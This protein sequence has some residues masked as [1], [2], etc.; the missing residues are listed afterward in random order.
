MNIL[1]YTTYQEIN[2]DWV[3]QKII[4][5][6]QKVN[7]GGGGGTTDHTQLINRDAANQH[8]MSAITGLS[9]ALAG[10]QPAG[11]YVTNTQLNGAVDDAL[12][13][14]KAS[15][16]FDGAQGPAGPAGDTGP[17]GPAGFSP[18]ASVEQTSTG[19]TITITDKD[20]TT[21][22]TVNNGTP[23]GSVAWEQLYSGD[24]GLEAAETVI[25]LT[26]QYSRIVGFVSG[27]V[28]S[29]DTFYIKLD[30]KTIITSQTWWDNSGERIMMFDLTNVGFGW[31]AYAND[32]GCTYSSWNAG[33]GS[34]TIMRVFNSVLEPTKLTIT[35]GIFANSMG[36]KIWGIPK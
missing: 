2:L 32:G 21:T 13:A 7:S 28:D 30:D 35:Y 27:L 20:G 10:K 18:S 26:K 6:E 16:E 36:L 34:S 9:T 15:G 12:A 17:Q 25:N 33:E 1:G 29:Q 4:E 31:L 3:I 23:G 11:N 5:L 8:P 19:A 22:A 24:A 14:A